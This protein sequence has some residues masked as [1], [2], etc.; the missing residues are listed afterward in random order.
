MQQCP[1]LPKS[2]AEKKENVNNSKKGGIKGEFLV[3]LIFNLE[4]I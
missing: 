2:L 3:L 1:I 4:E